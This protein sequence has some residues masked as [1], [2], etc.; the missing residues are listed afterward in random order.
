VKN[1]L[2]EKKNDVNKEVIDEKSN[3]RSS[4]EV[5]DDDVPVM[6]RAVSTGNFSTAK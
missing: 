3:G 5:E 4:K 2:I 6:L 1:V